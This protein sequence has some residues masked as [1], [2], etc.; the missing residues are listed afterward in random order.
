MAKAHGT[1]LATIDQKRAR[2]QTRIVGCDCV[3]M[4]LQQE[5]LK[6]AILS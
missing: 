1:P 3:S 5:T 6:H 4:R 2:T